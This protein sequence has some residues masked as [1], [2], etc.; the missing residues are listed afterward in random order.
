MQ[1]T[2]MTNF[3]SPDVAGST[4]NDDFIFSLKVFFGF[5]NQVP[6]ARIRN[7]VQFVP[8]SQVLKKKGPV[9]IKDA[10]LT[11]ISAAHTGALLCFCHGASAVVGQISQER[12][13]CHR[14]DSKPQS[15]QA[16]GR[17]PAP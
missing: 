8:Y 2:D 11:V 10:I 1:G 14:R 17:R 5:T 15:H 7:A 6:F 13:S 4:L 3:I 9:S 12:H 16:S